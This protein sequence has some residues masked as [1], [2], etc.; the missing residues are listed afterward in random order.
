MNARVPSAGV[1]CALLLLLP[2]LTLPPRA[3]GQEQPNS[4]VFKRYKPPDE[5]PLLPRNDPTYQIWQAFLAARRANAGDPLAQHELGLRYLLGIGVERDTVKAALWIQKAAE[6]NLTPAR[7][8][9]AILKYQGWGTPWDPFE[10][11]RNFLYCAQRDV[12]E[13][14]FAVGL[15]HVENLVMPEDW[16]AGQGWVKKAADA[17]FEPAKKALPLFDQRLASEGKHHRSDSLI[18]PAAIIPFQVDAQ[19]DSVTTVEEKALLRDAIVRADPELRKSLGLAK[20]I[21]STS[22]VDSVSLKSIRRSA[23]AGS[24][25]ALALLG[26]LHEQGVLVRKDPLAAASFYLRG[27]RMESQR[28]GKL[29]WDLA[30]SSEFIALMKSRADAGDSV[31]QYVWAGLFT[32]GAEPF[33]PGGKAFITKEQGLQLLRKSADKRYLPAMIE[34]ALWYYAGRWVPSDEQRAL[35]YLRQAA[36][37]GSMEAE[38]RLAVLEVRAGPDEERMKQLIGLLQRGREE[39]SLLA[40]VALGYAHEVGIGVPKSFA[41]AAEHYRSAWRRGSQDAYRALRRMHDDLRPPEKE[42]AMQD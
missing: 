21:D 16:K 13:A 1:A 37:G 41:E 17:G 2:L 19:R 27:F 39:G 4:P 40:E 26:K 8:N 33:Q 29:L 5:I 20:M 18:S 25:E 30:R 10:A 11:Y 3:P 34:C 6:Q 31:G 12:P 23:D 36:A 42:F 7:F 38:I 14:E 35:A 32:L 28:A 22:T 9:F 15:A 24:P